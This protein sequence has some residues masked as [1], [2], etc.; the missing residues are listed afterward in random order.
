MVSAHFLISSSESMPPSR[1]FVPRPRPI[2]WPRAEDRR[3]AVV[4]LR[5]STTP[6]RAAFRKD[7]EI[8]EA[9]ISL[10]RL[11]SKPAQQCF[12][13]LGFQCY[14]SDPFFHKELLKLICND[15]KPTDEQI[16]LYVF[17]QCTLKWPSATILSTAGAQSKALRGFLR[18]KTPLP[19]LDWSRS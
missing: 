18:T 11:R 12:V 13:D 19:E 7:L 15:L 10:P 9:G 17:C 1:S 4:S 14:A 6:H 16:V 5:N 8:V 2:H 3:S